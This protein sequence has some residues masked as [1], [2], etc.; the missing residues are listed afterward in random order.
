MT[1]SQ[2]LETSVEQLE[3]MSDQELREFL[4]PFLKRVP[5]TK[6]KTATER[7]AKALVDQLDKLMSNKHE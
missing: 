4:A 7:D 3:A 6:R 1:I 5:P 2:L